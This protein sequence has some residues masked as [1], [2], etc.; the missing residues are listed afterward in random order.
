MIPIQNLKIGQVIIDIEISKHTKTNLI[1]V[2]N[3][4]EEINAEI[5]NVFNSLI[6]DN[7]KNILNG[8]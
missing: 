3:V 6:N 7:T 2:Q 4:F 5:F 8:N 1:D